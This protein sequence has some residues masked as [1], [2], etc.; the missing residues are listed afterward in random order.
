MESLK[1]YSSLFLFSFLVGGFLNLPPWA[2]L[3]EKGYSCAKVTWLAGAGRIISRNGTRSRGR[4]YSSE[5][6]VLGQVT[7]ER[8]RKGALAFNVH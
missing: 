4:A 1:H 6:C 3:S 8:E 5:P 7:R 2:L